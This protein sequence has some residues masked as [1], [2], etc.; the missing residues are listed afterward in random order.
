MAEKP[1]G[2]ALARASA[3]SHPAAEPSAIRPVQHRG[4]AAQLVAPLWLA[5]DACAFT[6]LVYRGLDA[7]LLGWL[8]AEALGPAIARG[9]GWLALAAAVPVAG[10]V[11]P[12]LRPSRSAAERWWEVIVVLG[13]LLT[14][15]ITLYAIEPPRGGS[16]A[17]LG[18]R[19]HQFR[20]DLEIC[21]DVSPDLAKALLTALV[22]FSWLLIGE[23]R[24]TR[25]LRRASLVGI[26]LAIVALA[27]VDPRVARVQRAGLA[28]AVLP[29]VVLGLSEVARARWAARVGIAAAAFAFVGA[30]EAGLAPPRDGSG[31]DS[32]R[33]WTTIAP[34][35]HDAEQP[36]DLPISAL[37]TTPDGRFALAGL[38]TSEGVARI[39]LE[40]GGVAPLGLGEPV[41]LLAFDPSTFDAVAWL[42]QRRELLAL[43]TDPIAIRRTAA[44]LGT[45]SEWPS[46]LAVP[47][48]SVVLGHRDR[49]ALD[50]YA[51]STLSPMRGREIAPPAA[52][53]ARSWGV[54]AL[55]V[56][57]SAKSVYACLVPLDGQGGSLVVRAG[58]NESAQAP[59]AAACDAF[60]A[61][62]SRSGTVHVLV[63]DAVTRDVADLEGSTLATLR[64]LRGPRDVRTLVYEP[65][66]DV[67]IALGRLSRELAVIDL[68]LGDTAKRAILDAVPRACA[69]DVRRDRLLVGD[70]GGLHALPLADWL[71]PPPVESPT[72]TA[73]AARS[74]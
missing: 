1:S 30:H 52:R 12:S 21:A 8:D 68:R 66:R 48:A 2:S 71:Y 46:A 29:L 57:A 39:D 61:V 33:G 58:A 24:A 59:V 31:L 28:V 56:A 60:A 42:P 64:T 51:R 10:Q 32:A 73:A 27:V 35:G 3:G 53:A 43:A 72:A 4:L 41:S 67:V 15:G 63:G 54:R 25:W 23:G 20:R 7:L 40:R 11:L 26:A 38:A 17:E 34:T 6:G 65:R 47:L 19:C 16:L 18:W 62:T 45:A 36:L 50:L 70:D 5:L 14:A 49:A 22:A 37:L 69:V 44:V 13:V 55:A 74:R 9:L